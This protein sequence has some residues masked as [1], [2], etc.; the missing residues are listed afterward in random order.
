MKSRKG[1]APHRV[2]SISF[3]SLS[4]Q[5]EEVVP[6]PNPLSSEARPQPFALHRLGGE[7]APGEVLLAAHLV[8]VSP[9][10]DAAAEFSDGGDSARSTMY[11]ML[12]S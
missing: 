11:C 12:Y 2:P 8:D 9:Q 4:T 6:W 5:P 3:K 1:W 10:G 7:L